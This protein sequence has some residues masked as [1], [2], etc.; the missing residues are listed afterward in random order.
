[1]A[2]PV[3][4][5]ERTRPAGASRS[6]RDGLSRRD[7]LPNRARPADSPDAPGPPRRDLNRNGYPR[8]SNGDYHTHEDG[9]D[10]DVQE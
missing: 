8:E 6:K 7:F 1:M 10:D 3:A 5:T 9:H 4:I 2:R